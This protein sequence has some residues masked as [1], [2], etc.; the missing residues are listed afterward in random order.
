MKKLLGIIILGL[1]LSG[2][3]YS[4][5]IELKKC[6]RG[7]IKFDPSYYEKRSYVIDTNKSKVQL[8]GVLTNKQYKI[9]QKEFMKEFGSTEGLD[10]ISV[11]NFNIEYADSQYVKAVKKWTDSTGAPIET[12]IEIDLDDKT[13]LYKMHQK[14]S[15]TTH[16]CK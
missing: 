1:L 10:K 7:S 11:M 4:K 14:S 12:T 13:V 5:V 9:Y 8:V 2:N 15:G 6:S 16:K 3:A